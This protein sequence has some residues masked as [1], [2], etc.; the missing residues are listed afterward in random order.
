LDPAQREFLEEAARDIGERLRV[1]HAQEDERIADEIRQRGVRLVQYPEV[2]LAHDIAWKLVYWEY[3][4]T[5]A[6]DVLDAIER[7]R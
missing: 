5:S 7:L 4:K 3:A 2:Q 1:R 6:F